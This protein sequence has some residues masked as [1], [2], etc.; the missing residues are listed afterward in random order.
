MFGIFF[1]NGD[2]HTCYLNVLGVHFIMKAVLLPSVELFQ[3][4]ENTVTE[5]PSYSNGCYHKDL[6]PFSEAERRQG[7]DL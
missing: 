3:H 5:R 6:F 7:N 4:Y 2:K 1:L